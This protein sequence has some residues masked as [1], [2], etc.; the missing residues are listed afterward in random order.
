MSSALT[1][2]LIQEVNVTWRSQSLG[3]RRESENFK[4]RRG[5]ES[6]NSCVVRHIYYAQLKIYIIRI[7]TCMCLA[8]K[9]HIIVSGVDHL[10]VHPKCVVC[11]C[12]IKFWH[13]TLYMVFSL[14]KWV[15]CWLRRMELFQ[16]RFKRQIQTLRSL[17]CFQSVFTFLVH[18]CNA[19]SVKQLDQRPKT[20]HEKPSVF[21]SC[22][23][24]DPLPLLQA[25]PL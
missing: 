20:D 15:Q 25:F 16:Q 2:A 8:R 7:S 23:L 5:S 18:S 24:T 6:E 14:L 17:S 13:Y 11:I 19:L 9:I 12:F 1:Q 22:F 10:L 3:R 4:G 21:V